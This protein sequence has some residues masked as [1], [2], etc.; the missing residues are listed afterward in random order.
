MAAPQVNDGPAVDDDGHAT[1]MFQP[2]GETL[3]E[4]LAHGGKAR[5]A[6]TI[7]VHARILTRCG[8]DVCRR[9][10][11]S[12]LAGTHQSS[13]LPASTYCFTEVEVPQ[14]SDST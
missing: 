9:R 13:E 8:R 10:G 3:G 12:G 4:S 5:I 14:V 7:Y 2:L 6:D 1:A 11:H